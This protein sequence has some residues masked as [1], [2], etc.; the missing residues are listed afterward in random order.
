MSQSSSVQ[1]S[2]ISPS[3]QAPQDIV[4]VAAPS[5]K[6]SMI[7]SNFT[8]ML[9]VKDTRFDLSIYGS[10]LDQIPQR[11]GTNNALDA[12]AVALTTAMP[13]V[14]THQ[15]SANMYSS[16]ARALKSTRVSLSDPAEAQSPETLCAI[17]LLMVCQVNSNTVVVAAANGHIAKTNKGLDWKVR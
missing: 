7:T 16:Y 15:Y 3:N 14:Y 8:S 5:S 13:Y 9:E 11:L 17:Y 12:V 10:F 4:L 1:G 2:G 6:I